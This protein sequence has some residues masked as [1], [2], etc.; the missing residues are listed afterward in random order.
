MAT[1]SLGGNKIKTSGELPEKGKMAPQFKLAKSDLSEATL[2]DYTGRKVVMNI[3]PSVDT[4]VCA[5]SVRTFNKKASELEETV[6]LCISKDL[7]FA[8]A[9]FCAAEGL[10]NVESLSDFRTEDFG[11]DYGLK[12]TEGAFNGLLSRVVIVLNEEGKVIYTEQ[13]PEIGKE[14]NYDAA[15]SALYH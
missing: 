14:P 8:Q 12:I 2:E 15:L 10:E 13:V 7:P 4:G 3:F 1:I 6:V 5:T 9:R 11:S